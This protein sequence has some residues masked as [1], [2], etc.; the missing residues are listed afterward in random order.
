MHAF[1]R[2][3]AAIG[4]SKRWHEAGSMG[5]SSMGQLVPIFMR[6]NS[7]RPSRLPAR[8]RAARATGICIRL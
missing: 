5:L 1:H 3:D 4:R 6:A 7:P 2:V 8:F